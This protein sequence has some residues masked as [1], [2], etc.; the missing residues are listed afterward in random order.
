MYCKRKAEDDKKKRPLMTAIKEG[1]DG[2]IQLSKKGQLMTKIVEENDV[3]KQER[4]DR[5]T[6]FRQYIESLP[7]PGQLV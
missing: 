4:A 2:M 1:Q 6:K 7:E 5:M 3:M